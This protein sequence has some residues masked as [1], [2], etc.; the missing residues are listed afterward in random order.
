[1]STDTATGG[2]ERHGV[3]WF[4]GYALT[5][6][7]NLMCGWITNP[8]EPDI[9]MVKPCGQAASYEFQHKGHE[10]VWHAACA[11][12][13]GVVRE[14]DLVARIRSLP[15]PKQSGEPHV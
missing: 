8:D 13:A 11:V 7:D 9:V 10:F 14:L 2:S 6:P 5:R 15:S 3:S 1:M 4:F 12:H